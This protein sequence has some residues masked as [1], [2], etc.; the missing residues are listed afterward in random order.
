[1][2]PILAAKD[3]RPGMWI[4]PEGETYP[5]EVYKVTC[6]NRVENI[7]TGRMEYTKR[8]VYF[9]NFADAEFDIEFNAETLVP[10]F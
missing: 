1:M 7:A 10:T 9:S 8:R 6:S 3:I 2:N 4:R 5:R